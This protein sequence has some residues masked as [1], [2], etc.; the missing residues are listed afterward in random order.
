MGQPHSSSVQVVA[1]IAGEETGDA[2]VTP[3]VD[4]HRFMDQQARGITIDDTTERLVRSEDNPRQGHRINPTPP[5]PG[6]PARSPTNNH[7][8]IPTSVNINPTAPKRRV[9]IERQWFRHTETISDVVLIG[10][11]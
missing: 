4:V 1:E 11:R 10:S 7:R 5:H 6:K 3:L 2:V 9:K 8:P